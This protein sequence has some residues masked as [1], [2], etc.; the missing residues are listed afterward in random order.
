MLKTG[1]L[2][3]GQDGLG[4][5]H[6]RVQGMLKFPVLTMPTPGPYPLRLLEADGKCLA[7]FYQ[8]MSSPEP[9]SSS[10][11]EDAREENKNHPQTNPP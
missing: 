11:P 2:R 7:P 4:I 6:C 3:P 10:Q 1:R 5:L 8:P 9:P